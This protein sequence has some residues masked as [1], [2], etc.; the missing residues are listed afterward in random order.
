MT[1]ISDEQARDDLGRLSA[2][3]MSIVARSA[4]SRTATRIRAGRRR[5][6]GKTAAERFLLRWRGEADPRT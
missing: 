3:V 1:D 6:G 2:Q 5:R 4:A